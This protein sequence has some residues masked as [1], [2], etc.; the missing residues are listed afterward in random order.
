MERISLPDLK[1]KASHFFKLAGLPEWSRNTLLYLILNGLSAPVEIA[2]GAGVPRNKIYEVLD[3]LERRAL[4]Y[5]GS[6]VGEKKLYQAV[7]P[8]EVFELLA[9]GAYKMME[10]KTEILGRLV[11][12]YEGALAG[13][14][15]VPVEAL[16]MVTD[17]RTA[18]SSMLAGAFKGC[19]N[20]I[21]LS[22]A[23]FSWLTEAATLVAQLEAKCRAGITVKVLID[24]DLRSPEA[25]PTQQF[26]ARGFQVRK[27]KSV[28]SS[29]VIVDRKEIYVSIRKPTPK[30]T[31][32]PEVFVRV[33]AAE[34]A[35]DLVR[36]F[37]QAWEE[38]APEA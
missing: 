10:L 26:V 8:E 25:D 23:D 32:S 5:K 24:A 19:R 29:A 30:A 20:E 22:G 36:V 6:V 14:D 27:T 34:F 37:D 21:F 31:E 33:S 16:A 12:L 2:A 18:V 13:T 17:S 4:V 7:R 11:E 38:G 15:G 28:R 9:S 3:D 35:G 1:T